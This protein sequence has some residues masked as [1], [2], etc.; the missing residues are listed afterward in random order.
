MTRVLL[1]VS[2]VVP[3]SLDDDIAAGR[4]PRVDYRAMADASGFE[5]FASIHR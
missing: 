1:T 5:V 3:D 2:G 4:R